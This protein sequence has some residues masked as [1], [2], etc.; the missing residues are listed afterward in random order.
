LD[1]AS[2]FESKTP[3]LIHSGSSLLHSLQT[4]KI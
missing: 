4:L 1:S 3:P 2:Q